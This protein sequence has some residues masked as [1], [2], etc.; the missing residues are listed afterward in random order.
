MRRAPEPLADVTEK[1]W[2]AQLFNSVRGMA[3]ILGWRGYH[4][5]RSQGSKPGFPDRVIWR[6]RVIFVELKRESGK[7]TEAQAQVL[8]ELAKA[9]AEVYLWRPSDLD[10]VGKIL[11]TRWRWYYESRSLAG[12]GSEWRPSS[13]WMPTGGRWDDLTPA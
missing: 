10:E 2:D 12:A 6:D 8:T 7:A 3:T 9:G 5:L 1:A 4:T 11:A 13:I